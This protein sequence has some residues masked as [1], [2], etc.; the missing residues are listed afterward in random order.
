MSSGTTS[1]SFASAKNGMKNIINAQN[2]VETWGA[3]GG[4][5]HRKPFSIK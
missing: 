4:E 1:S 3:T 2:V 5:K